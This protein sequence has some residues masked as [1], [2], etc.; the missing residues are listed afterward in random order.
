VD[1]LITPKT[2]L[3]LLGDN[4]CGKSTLIK[5][6]LGVEKSD[7]GQVKLADNLQVAYFEQSSETLDLKKSVL[8][9]L[10]DEGD[11]VFFQGQ[12]VHIRSYLDRFFFSGHKAEMPVEKL[13]G[14][15]KARLRI[16]KLM[17]KQA[18]VLVLDE[19]TNDL[20]SDTLDNLEDSLRD[21]NG[22]VILVTHDRYF[23]DAVCNQILAFPPP[24]FSDRRLQKFANY[25]QWENWFQNNP[26]FIYIL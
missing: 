10:S 12:P 15:E 20:D 25:F 18:Q 1:L 21:F 6:L 3:G 5:T 24:E 26:T 19:P 22:A 17:L 16:A 14:G 11:Y 7:C 4:G 2:R 23:L 8:R 9:N 13:S